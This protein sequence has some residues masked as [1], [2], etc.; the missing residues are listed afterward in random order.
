L[1]INNNEE[2]QYKDIVD[3]SMNNDLIDFTFNNNDYEYLGKDILNEPVYCTCR[4]IYYGSM[5][6]CE[7]KTVKYY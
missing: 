5:I 4:K 1:N 7:N 2:T 3:I 6:E